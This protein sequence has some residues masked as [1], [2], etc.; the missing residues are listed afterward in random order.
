M[1][2]VRDVTDVWWH[3][4]SPRHSIRERRSLQPHLLCAWERHSDCGED[5]LLGWS[6]NVAR[7]KFASKSMSSILKTTGLEGQ[8]AQSMLISDAVRHTSASTTSLGRETA[9]AASISSSQVSFLRKPSAPP[10]RWS[11]S[12]LLLNYTKGTE[13]MCLSHA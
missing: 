6:A 9:G 5:T 3:M 1:S 10:G 2:Y 12:A 11:D 8:S 4:P 7:I 13:S